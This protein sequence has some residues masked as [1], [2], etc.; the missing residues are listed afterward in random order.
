[1]HDMGCILYDPLVWGEVDGVADHTREIYRHP[2][3]EVKMTGS[4]KS[5]PDGC[6]E[7]KHAVLS[8]NVF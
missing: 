6:R 2:A 5:T 8:A 7:K 3:R 4:S 1:M